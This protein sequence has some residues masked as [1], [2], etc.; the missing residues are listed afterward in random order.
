MAKK[1]TPTELLYM[2]EHIA[3]DR[4]PQIIATAIVC[5]TIA[6][7]AVTLRFISRRLAKAHYGWDDWSVGIALVGFESLAAGISPYTRSNKA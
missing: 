4:R 1:P 2:H 7:A 5:F 3:D 6:T